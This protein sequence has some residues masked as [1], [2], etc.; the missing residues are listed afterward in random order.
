MFRK[1]YGLLIRKKMVMIK[2]DYIISVTT[3]QIQKINKPKVTLKF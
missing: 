1:T 2:T 3:F